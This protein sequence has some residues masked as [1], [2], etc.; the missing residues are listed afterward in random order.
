MHAVGLI[1]A[2]RIGR[3]HARTIVSSIPN[4]QLA[5]VAD[6]EAEAAR[7]LAEEVGAD[8]TDVD[9]LLGA[10]DAVLITTPPDTHT[11][12]VRKAAAAGKHIFCEKPLATTVAAA[13]EALEAAEA[14]GVLF[15]I[16]YN[17][18]F[19]ARFRDVRDAVAQGRIGTPWLLRI[20]SRDPGPPPAA[21]LPHSGGLFFDT[22]SHDLDLARFVLG[23]EITEIAVRGASLVDPNAA[24]IG[25]VDT[26]VLSLAFANGAFGAI[27]NCRVSVYGYDQRLE[28]HGSAGLAS[29]DNDRRPQ[30]LLA[31]AAGFHEP[32]LPD[33]YIDR[34]A[35]AFVR[36]LESFANAL[37]GGDVE[38]TGRDGLAAVLAATAARR[39]LDEN[40]VVRL[41]E[42]A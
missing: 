1:G 3:F 29:A 40:R 4:L 22:T 13:R 11:E 27:D 7:G 32:T 24:A 20:T 15:Q 37:E 23:T 35:P 19:D 38:V 39:A 6:A 21:Y 2:G 25:D 17:R 33:F 42:I 31:D 34:Y 10:V 5:V 28:V 18:R 30:A 16:G 26:V 36:E 12:L 8:A 41:E 9:T 14:A